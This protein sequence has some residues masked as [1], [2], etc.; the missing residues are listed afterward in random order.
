MKQIILENPEIR[1]NTLRHVFGIDKYKRVL[2]NGLALLGIE[3]L[4]KM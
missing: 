1:L 3:S 2:E 4:E